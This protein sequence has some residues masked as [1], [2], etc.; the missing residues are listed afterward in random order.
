LG[1]CR[2]TLVAPK[3]KVINALQREGSSHTFFFGSERKMV[4]TLR[5]GRV[6]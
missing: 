1:N 5:K 3:R 2:R 4:S 6:P